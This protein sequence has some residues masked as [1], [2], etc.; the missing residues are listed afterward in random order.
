MTVAV[1]GWYTGRRRL[2][3]PYPKG[4]G[5]GR[6]TKT[7]RRGRLERIAE[8]PRPAGGGAR[9]FRL[10]AV[11][12]V[13]AVVA[14]LAALSGEGSPVPTA[15]VRSQPRAAI[16]DQLGS[17]TPNPSFV[18]TTTATLEEAGYAVDYYGADQVTVEFLRDL[19]T[20]YYDLVVLRGHSAIPGK[21]LTLPKDVDPATLDRIMRRIG[22]DVLLFTSE[23]YDETAYL[24]DQKALRLFPVVYRGDPMSESYFAIA[25]GFVESSMSGRFDG[26][27]VILMGCSS[28]A[29]DRTAAAFVDRGAGAVVGWS[30]TVSPEHT[31]AATERLVEHLVKDHLPVAEAVADTMSEVGPDPSYGAIMRAYPAG[32]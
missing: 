1:G 24:D 14:C 2:Q 23:P 17:R 7:K 12:V 16:I 27:T 6:K 25:S 31:D 18:E 22:N 15:G 4:V 5:L 30:D 9:L 3:Q 21:D 8:E 32:G 10:L 19:P 28:L 11:L 20:H 13:V 29:S 26:T